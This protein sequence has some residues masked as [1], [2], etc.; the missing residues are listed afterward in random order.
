MPAVFFGSLIGVES[1]PIIGQTNQMIVFGITV[2]WSIYTTSQKACELIKKEKAAEDKAN[3]V[4]V[5]SSNETP[6]IEEKAE[7][8]Q[9]PK[10]ET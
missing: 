7:V 2:A 3:G 4:V 8:A 9:S 6:L 5:G 1:G 10:G